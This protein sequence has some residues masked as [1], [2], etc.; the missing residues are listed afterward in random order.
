MEKIHVAVDTLIRLDDIKQFLNNKFNDIQQR[1]LLDI[2]ET[3]GNKVVEIDIVNKHIKIYEIARFTHVNLTPIR[4]LITSGFS[5]DLPTYT[6]E[7]VQHKLSLKNIQAIYIDRSNNGQ[8]YILDFGSR[9]VLR[10]ELIDDNPD[11]YLVIYSAK[12]T[13]WFMSKVELDKFSTTS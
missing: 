5:C 9:I 3:G 10:A 2:Y 7:D 6:V 13:Q 4:Q 1:V 11:N 8:S 12:N